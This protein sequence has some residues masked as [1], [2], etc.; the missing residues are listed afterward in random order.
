MKRKNRTGGISLPD[1]RLYYKATVIK[2]A[3]YKNR[4]TDQWNRVDSPE[5]TPNT[6]GQL[7]YD[8]GGKNMQWKKESL[9]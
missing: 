6:Y 3:W 9:Q 1:F 7:I 5:I 4:N 2:M 8:E